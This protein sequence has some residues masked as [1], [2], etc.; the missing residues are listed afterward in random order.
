MS[1]LDEPMPRK[2]L[3]LNITNSIPENQLVVGLCSYI[4]DTMGLDLD[5]VEYQIEYVL[6]YVR[7]AKAKMK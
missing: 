4:D 5:G 3:Y 6:N 1:V 7:N 2:T